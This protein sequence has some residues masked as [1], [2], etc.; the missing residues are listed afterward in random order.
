MR[1]AIV[2]S[3]RSGN[4]WIRSTLAGVLGW[5]DIPVHDVRDSPPQLPEDCVLQIHWRREPAFQAWLAEHRIQVLTIARHPLDVLL[6][7]VRFGRHEPEVARWLN[8]ATDLPI[9]LG[10][11]GSASPEFLRYCLSQGAAHLLSVTPD[12]WDQPDVM[13]LRYETVVA[14]PRR[15]LGPIIKTLGGD[16]ANLGVWLERK[17]LASFQILPNRHGWRGIP[18]HWTELIPSL[19]AAKIYNRHRDVFKRLGYSFPLSWL[20]R[21]AAARNWNTVS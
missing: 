6:S 17:N 10:E 4:S 15:E 11:A 14:D 1:V 2:S 18:D 20:G 21:D 9:T 19:D 8:G 16:P 5:S 12:W 13:Q 3:P 7:A